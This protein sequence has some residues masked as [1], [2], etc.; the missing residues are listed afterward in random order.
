MQRLISGCRVFFVYAIDVS[1]LIPRGSAGISRLQEL[2]SNRG[3]YSALNKQW[4]DEP[5]YVP[6]RTRIEERSQAAV[7]AGGKRVWTRLFIEQNSPI[8]MPSP[9]HLVS[10]STSIALHSPMTPHSDDL[11]DWTYDESQPSISR[12][13]VIICTV[14]FRSDAAIRVDDAIEQIKSL[15]VAAAHSFRDWVSSLAR[16]GSPLKRAFDNLN[17]QI[18]D[19]VNDEAINAHQLTFVK[20]IAESD[21]SPIPISDLRRSRE[22][23][24]LLNGASWYEYYNQN[25]LDRLASQDIGYR[26]DE[27]YITDNKASLVVQN[28]YW[29]VGDSLRQY[30][31]DLIL[32]TEYHLGKRIFL[33][34]QLDYARELDDEVDQPDDPGALVLA[35]DARPSAV[36]AV[37]TSRAILAS[38]YESLNFAS[39]VNHGFTQRYLEGMVNESGLGPALSD[40]ERR[41]S[42]TSLAVELDSAVAADLQANRVNRT[43]V[44]LTVA[45]AV[46]TALLIILGILGV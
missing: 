25:Y 14:S 26:T 6:A 37:L 3:L 43:L 36:T 24:G 39:L 11:S 38:T 27:L 34:G 9:P 16:N 21:G 7:A 1:S 18:E 5:T 20:E 19:D 46:L 12:D 2:R 35:D 17:V 31:G 29:R 42:N 4:R 28:G 45:V 40:I 15:R 44:R 41:I 13:G 32:A 30:M 23:A 8:T 33:R 22:V 10:E